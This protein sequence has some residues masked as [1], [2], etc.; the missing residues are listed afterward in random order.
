MEINLKRIAKNE[1]YTIGGL[2][3]DG[4]YE[5]E[6]LEPTDRGLRQ[7]MT[8]EEIASIKVPGKTAIPVGRYKV[9][10]TLSSRFHRMLPVLV[11]VPGF[12]G[13]RVHSGN[14]ASE[15]SGCILPGE[16][17]VKGKVIKSMIHEVAIRDKISAAIEGGEECYMTIT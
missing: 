15:T 11:D 10:V 8:L 7:D 13:I 1:D 16:N 14:K 17:K 4:V 5:C 6:T 2:S 12:E 3:I 9:E